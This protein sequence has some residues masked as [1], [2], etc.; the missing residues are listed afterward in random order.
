M[1]ERLWEYA[2]AAEDLVFHLLHAGDW[3][4]RLVFRV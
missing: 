1:G 4:V 2:H 3:Q